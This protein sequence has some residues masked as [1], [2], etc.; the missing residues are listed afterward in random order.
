MTPRLQQVPDGDWFCTK[1]SPVAPPLASLLRDGE[2]FAASAE[3]NDSLVGRSIA[4][5][6][7]TGWERAVVRK[8]YRKPKKGGMNVETKFLDGSLI[9]ITITAGTYAAD[10]AAP[11]AAWA[12]MSSFM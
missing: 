7:S 9:D 8:V 11:L 5:K 10:D 12:L 3:I 4:F 6:W 1:C 2:T